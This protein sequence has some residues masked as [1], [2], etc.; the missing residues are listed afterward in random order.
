LARIGEGELT[1]DLDDLGID[2][3]T[4]LC[5]LPLGGSWLTSDLAGSSLARPAN[6]WRNNLTVLRLRSEG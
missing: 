6:R 1:Q 4:W 2:I 3:C 5:Y